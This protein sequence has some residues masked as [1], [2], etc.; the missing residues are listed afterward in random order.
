VGGIYRH[1][2]AVFLCTRQLATSLIPK[3]HVCHTLKPILRRFRNVLRRVDIAGG[4]VVLPSRSWLLMFD[5]VLASRRCIGDS[6]TRTRDHQKSQVWTRR[7]QHLLTNI[8]SAMIIRS[9]VR[10]QGPRSSIKR[11]CRIPYRHSQ[12]VRRYSTA[13]APSMS[14]SAPQSQASMLATITTDLDKIAP[15]FE[16][17]PE[18]IE[19]LRSPAEFYETLKVRFI[20]SSTPFHFETDRMRR[21]VQP[22]S[23]LKPNDMS[24]DL[25]VLKSVV[26][27]RNAHIAKHAWH[28]TCFALKRD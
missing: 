9:L 8:R 20:T 14:S 27:S 10:A 4:V 11:A 21:I 5:D 3:L 12:V 15:R 25:V 22:T 28:L 24:N 26:C 1:L 19:I 7:L 16:I 13:N 23:F 17:Q 2:V 18:Q 6:A